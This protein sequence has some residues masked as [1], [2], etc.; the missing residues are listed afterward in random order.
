VNPL[1]AA[2]VAAA[3]RLKL[4]WSS[5]TQTLT[6]SFV[7]LSIVSWGRSPRQGVRTV[8][9]TVH[10]EQRVRVLLADLTRVDQFEHP[11][12]LPSGLDGWD[13]FAASS[14][15]GADCDV[16]H[17]IAKS[18]GGAYSTRDNRRDQQVVSRGAGR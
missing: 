7:M 13:E 11:M 18:R 6:R 9:G 14:D 1:A 17:G 10:E 4:A 3:A 12:R 8:E 15:H 2:K 5:T 16:G